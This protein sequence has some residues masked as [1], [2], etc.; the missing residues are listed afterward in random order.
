MLYYN[1]SVQGVISSEQCPW[2]CH[3]TTHWLLFCNI[4]TVSL[5]LLHQ[6]NIFAAVTSSHCPSSTVTGA[7]TLT[8][9][10][11]RCIMLRQDSVLDAE[12]STHSP[13]SASCYISSVWCCYISQCPWCCNITTVSW[14]QHTVLGAETSTLSCYISTVY[15]VLWQ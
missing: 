2:Y 14:Y 9:C 12:M 6:H 11:K 3:E 7:E 5:I 15:L 4:S 1:R 8:W 10:I 13:N